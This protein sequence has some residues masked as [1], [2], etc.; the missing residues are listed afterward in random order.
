MQ[1]LILNFLLIDTFG[2]LGPEVGMQGKSMVL[3]LRLEERN[4][5]G[6]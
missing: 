2:G 1:S 4:S 5:L 3:N 6:D